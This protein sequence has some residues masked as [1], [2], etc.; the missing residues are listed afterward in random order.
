MTVRV[1]MALTLVAASPGWAQLADGGLEFKVVEPGG[2]TPAEVLRDLD[3]DAGEP[4]AEVDAGVATAPVEPVKEEPSGWEVTAK[5]SGSLRAAYQ[6]AS[7]FPLDATLVPAIIAPLTTRVRVNP[8]V[9]LAGFGLVAE[10]DTSTGAIVGTPDL[11]SSLP[12]GFALTDQLAARVTYPRISALELR[13]LY[14]EYAW[15]SGVVRVG[16]QTSSWGL[17]L[18]ANDGGRDPEAGDF[19][20]QQF[21]NLTYRALIVDR[22]FFN[23]GG[24]W[25]AFEAA[26]AVDLVVRDTNADFA[27]GDRAYQAVVALRFARDPEHSVGAYVVYR[28]QRNLFATD[29]GKALDVL[30]VDVAGLWEVHAR[31]NRSFKVGFEVVGITGT[32]TQARNDAAAVLQV[33]QLGLAVKTVYRVGRTRFLFDGGY[34]S[35]DQNP[36][37]DRLEAFRFDRDFKVGLVLFD[38]V[39]AYQ[40]ARSAV[41]ASDPNLAGVP[42][43]GTELLGTGGAVTGAWYLFPRLA[44]GANDW[45]DLYGGPLFAFSTAKLAD[46]FN[47]RLGG[48]APVNALGAAPGSYLGTELDLGAQVHWRPA[49]EVLITLTGEGGVF[50]PGD[51]FALPEGGLMGPVGFGRLR[52][53]LSI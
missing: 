9:H 31:R 13:K 12:A 39:L 23:N 20:Q 48:G 3:F 16:Q 17:G 8:E 18:L 7:A 6:G 33:R 36:G 10:A 40:S 24:A 50:L 38:H 34:A 2:Q 53:A 45:L 15:E 43:E 35:G 26:L 47:T 52:L 1:V 46:P 51:A 27:R 21:G 44:F 30:A 19:G 32:S 4:P 41:R 14:L 25:K 37:D 28:S 42:P 22:P 11:I 29:G 5:L 49:P